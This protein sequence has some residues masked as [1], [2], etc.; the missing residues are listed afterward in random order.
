MLMTRL[1]TVECQATPSYSLP[2]LCPSSPA[3][4]MSSQAEQI[5]LHPVSPPSL[6]TQLQLSGLGPVPQAPSGPGEKTPLLHLPTWTPPSHLF[7]PKLMFTVIFQIKIKVELLIIS[8]LITV[9]QSWFSFTVTLFRSSSLELHIN[10][11]YSIFGPHWLHLLYIILSHHGLCWL[12]HHC[13]LGTPHICY[14]I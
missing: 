7:T 8:H 4:I 6:S 1:V 5:S 13:L 12:R 9:L 2:A 11:I 3:P 10:D 14:I